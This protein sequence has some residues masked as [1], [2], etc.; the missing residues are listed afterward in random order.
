MPAKCYALARPR[1][2]TARR[3]GR[4]QVSGAAGSRSRVRAVVFPHLALSGTR[5]RCH[6]FAPGLRSRARAH[7]LAR[8]ER[9]CR[10]TVSRRQQPGELQP[11]FEKFTVPH[12]QVSSVV[13]LLRYCRTTARRYLP[14]WKK[15]TLLKERRHIG[16]GDWNA[17]FMICLII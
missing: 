4:W 16:R 15:S 2:R 6:V 3:Q 17:S 12:V 9:F 8:R 10:R 14:V 11:L 5:C 13:P 1:R 7:V